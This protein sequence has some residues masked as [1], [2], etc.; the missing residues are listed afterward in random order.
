VSRVGAALLIAGFAHPAAAAAQT[1]PGPPPPA[2]EL[3]GARLGAVAPCAEL[4]TAGITAARAG[5]VVAAER[6]L[7]AAHGL[8]PDSAAVSLE[9]SGLRFRQERYAEAAALAASALALDPTSAH[10]W[11]LLASSRFLLGDAAGAL[12]AWNRVG[13]PVHDGARFEGL[14]RTP[15]EVVAAA[16]GIPPGMTVT[17]EALARARRRVAALPTVSRS[18]VDYRPRPGGRAE[19]EAALLERPLLPL[20]WPDLIGHGVRAGSEARLR[21]DAAAPLD[22]GELW[23]LDWVWQQNRRALEIGIVLPDAIR[24][25]GTVEFA[26]G[27]RTGT[28]RLSPEGTEVGSSTLRETRRRLAMSVSDWATSRVRWSASALL[29]AWEARGTF[30]GL[31]V[32]LDLSPPNARAALRLDAR[33]WSA[34]GR[35]RFHAARIDGALR[36][37]AVPRVLEWTARAG[38]AEATSQ[39]PR[40]VWFGAGSGRGA[41]VLLR[42][43]P[44]VDDEGV[45]NGRFHAP[46]LAHAHVEL[47]AWAGHV[48][49]VRVGA[50]TFADA[51]RAGAAD[52]DRARDSE[53]RASPDALE[54]R[55]ALD[56]GAGL[57]LSVPGLPG[58]VR[59][60]IARDLVDGAVA[61]SIGW[62]PA[63]PAW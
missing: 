60:D 30:V 15:P 44:L 39:A 31:G 47:R 21:L 23:R 13:R 52:P 59:A 57:R 25:P 8:C 4:M 49:P 3:A 12:R 22:R 51:V 26:A 20:G 2:H 11:E 36:S 1:P 63:W 61:Y 58:V 28:Y 53:A 48:G 29:D 6:A 16:V 43:H 7:G 19:V 41:D 10:G 40:D 33:G 54:P 38:L 55:Y 27:A 45:V 24:L 56:A 35:K 32:G 42:A 18:R 9:L 34:A 62:T 17:P 5:D 50:A 37:A 14:A 46:R